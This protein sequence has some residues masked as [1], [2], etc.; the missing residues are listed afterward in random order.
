MCTAVSAAHRDKTWQRF[1]NV[2]MHT[3]A[4]MFSSSF[5][6]LFSRGCFEWN[7]TQTEGVSFL[8]LL[9][10]QHAQAAICTCVDNISAITLLL[11]QILPSSHG[12]PHPPP[13]LD[14]FLRSPSTTLSTGSVLCVFSKLSI[15]PGPVFAWPVLTLLTCFPDLGYPAC[16]YYWSVCLNDWSNTF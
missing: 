15:I 6:K 13:H 2:L 4:D 11:F 7:L 9:M 3:E 14:S 16:T 10:L 12:F 5:V 8:F 1:I